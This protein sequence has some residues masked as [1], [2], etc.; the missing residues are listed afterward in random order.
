[1]SI[2]DIPSLPAAQ[3]SGVDDLVES[4]LQWIC[5]LQEEWFLIILMC[6][7]LKWWKSSFPQVIEVVF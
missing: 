6:L 5:F 2:R 4:V 3:C 7:L 1:M